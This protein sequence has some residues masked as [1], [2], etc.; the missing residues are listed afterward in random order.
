MSSKFFQKT[1]STGWIVGWNIYG[2]EEIPATTIRVPS[3]TLNIVEAVPALV[4]VTA[5]PGMTLEEMV[6]AAPTSITLLLVLIPT[7]GASL[8]LEKVTESPTAT[9]DLEFIELL[10]ELV[11]L[12]VG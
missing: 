9:L 4:N 7:T 12:L 6:L 5:V 2:V 8:I 3:A 1:S 11:R 10:V